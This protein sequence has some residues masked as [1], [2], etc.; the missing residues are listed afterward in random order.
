MKFSLPVLSLA[1]AFF[2]NASPV[3]IGDKFNR[4]VG[5]SDDSHE[6]ISRAAYTAN[7]YLN[8]GCE[9]TVLVFARGTLQLGNLVSL[10]K[11]H[12]SVSR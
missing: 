4:S 10:S 5:A 12:S 11:Y 3:T 7:E 1:L 2:V 6:L 8:G 9:D